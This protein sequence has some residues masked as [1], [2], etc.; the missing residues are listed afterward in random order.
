MSEYVY[1]EYPKC[2][3]RGDE[4]VTVRSRTEEDVC[5]KEGWVT[6]DAFHATVPTESKKKKK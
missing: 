2:L 4:T 3:Y 5:A 1:V 6:A